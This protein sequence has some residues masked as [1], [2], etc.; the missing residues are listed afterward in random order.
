MRTTTTVNTANVT[1]TVVYAASTIT[2]REKKTL[3]LILDSDVAREKD[4]YI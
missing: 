3:F 1:A 4:F 2:T